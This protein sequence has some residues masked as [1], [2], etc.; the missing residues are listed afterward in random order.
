[1]AAVV[2]AEDR[3]SIQLVA[4][5]RKDFKQGMVKLSSHIQP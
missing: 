3:V 4:H 2:V 1:M 5:V